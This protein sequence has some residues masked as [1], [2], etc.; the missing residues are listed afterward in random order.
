[1]Q[2][3]SDS[4]GEWPRSGEIDIAESR[5]NHGDNYTS[6]GRDSIISALHWG[7]LSEVDAFWKTSGQHWVRRTD[8]S[9]EFHTFGLEWSEDYLFT[10]IDS[11]LLV[12]CHHTPPYSLTRSNTKTAS[13]LHQVQ[14]TDVGSRS[15]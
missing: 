1:M 10:Y 11:R 15:I 8:Y 4:Y 2:P 12:C 13:L 5:G 9:A 3:E 6:G 7:P 14:Q